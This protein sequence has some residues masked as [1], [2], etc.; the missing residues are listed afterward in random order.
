MCDH[1][2]AEEDSEED[3]GWKGRTECPLVV[4]VKE[5][6]LPGQSPS[7]VEWRGSGELILTETFRLEPHTV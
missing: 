2:K 7:S 6:F 5:R 1:C 3:G 4:F